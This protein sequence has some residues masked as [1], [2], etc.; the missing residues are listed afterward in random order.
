MDSVNMRSFVSYRYGPNSWNQARP[1][2]MGLQALL[3]D[4]YFYDLIRSGGN[5][6][7]L[8]TVPAPKLPTL[9]KYN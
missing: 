5:P 6:Y 7:Q 4:Y 9:S 8:P 2:V 1:A 3:S